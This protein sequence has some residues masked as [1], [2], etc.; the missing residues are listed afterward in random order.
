MKQF[1]IRKKNGK[2]RTIYKPSNSEKKR[3]SAVVNDLNLAQVFLTSENHVLG[4]VPGRNAVD[5]AKK[6]IGYQFTL[7]ADLSDFFDT[8]TK[9]KFDEQAGQVSK[10]IPFSYL[11]FPDN[12]ARQGLPTSPAIAN[13]A[14]TKL[15][16]ELITYCD[17][18]NI[19]YSRYADDLSFSCN[20]KN[21]LLEL[22][23]KLKD[24]V[25]QS[26]FV[27]NEK[28]TRLQWAGKDG[29]WTREIVGVGVN[30]T[31]VTPL[32]ISKRKLRAANHNSALN[33]K[34][35]L[36]KLKANGLAEWNKL[37]PANPS[38]TKAEASTY[39]VTKIIKQHI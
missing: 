39:F 3:L 21:I 10:F 34:N 11:E 17:A 27:L 13:I 16:T 15:D 20:D 12:A 36:L 14:A 24:I 8:V 26:G 5:C 22:R 1:K 38:I 19:V 35:K 30:K 31:S 33:P 32:R 23:S 25:T 7:S 18:N 4:F 9:E 37:I 29:N 6:H 2:F 28:K